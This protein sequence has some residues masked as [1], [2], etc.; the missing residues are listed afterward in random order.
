MSEKTQSK[1]AKS[2][3][4]KSERPDVEGMPVEKCFEELELIVGA[5]ESQ[6][7]SLDESLRLFERGMTL[8]SR[9]TRE[10]TEIERKIQLIIENSKGDVELKDFEPD[11]DQ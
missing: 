9:C 3:S 8:S 2:G 4:G 5:L 6:G 10:L 1:S 11:E 7:T